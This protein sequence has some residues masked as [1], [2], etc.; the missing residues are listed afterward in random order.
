ML[1]Y[2]QISIDLHGFFDVLEAAHYRVGFGVGGKHRAVKGKL[3]DRASSAGRSFSHSCRGGSGFASFPINRHQ[4][5]DA[6]A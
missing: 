3:K 1:Y 4:E 5:E 2:M 6:V